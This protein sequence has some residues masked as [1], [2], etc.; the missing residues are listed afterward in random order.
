MSILVIDP[1]DKD[2]FNYNQVIHYTWVL[3]S[4]DFFT[5]GKTPYDTLQIFMTN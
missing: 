5:L 3:K 2:I 1:D 4:G